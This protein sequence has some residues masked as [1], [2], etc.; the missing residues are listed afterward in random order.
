MFKKATKSRVFQDVVDQVQQAILD[1]QLKAGDRLPAEREMVEMF[2]TSRGTLREALRVLEHKGLIEIRLGVAGGA[3]VKAIDTEQV[4]E[5]LALLM[6]T[7]AIPLDDLA[8]FREGVEGN[9]SALAARRATPEDGE[10]LRRLMDEA[11]HFYE[12]G[13]EAWQSF[14]RVDRRIHM[15]LARISRNAIYA[16]VLKSV[17]DNIPPYYERYLQSSTTVLEE[18]YRDLCDLTAAVQAGDAA[19]A[20]RAAQAHVRRFHRYMLAVEH[21]I[22]E[23]SP[24]PSR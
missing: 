23:K 1:G 17:H 22:T 7:Q 10:D 9:V 21:R 18:N 3:M 8:E 11:R 19:A 5:S 14:V 16:F 24:R 13:V 12:Q 15:T 4:S 20:R 6:R 2:Q